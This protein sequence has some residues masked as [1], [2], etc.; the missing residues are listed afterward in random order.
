M[1]LVLFFP[2]LQIKKKKFLSR[3]SPDVIPG[4]QQEGKVSMLSTKQFDA[5]WRRRTFWP[6]RLRQ[7][8]YERSWS[9]KDLKTTNRVNSIPRFLGNEYVWVGVII[10]LTVDFCLCSH[11][12]LTFLPSRWVSSFPEPM[13]SAEGI[14]GPSWGIHILHLSVLQLTIK[15]TLCLVIWY[16]RVANKMRLCFGEG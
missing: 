12:H 6:A 2:F 3:Y 15:I 16:S 5:M 14:R 8:F 13:L 4:G 1:I 7:T 11:G 9:E 10:K